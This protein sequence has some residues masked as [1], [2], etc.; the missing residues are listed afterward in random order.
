M[1][2]QI[3]AELQAKVEAVAALLKKGYQ[4]HEGSPSLRKQPRC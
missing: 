3:T 1:S 4:D 2:E